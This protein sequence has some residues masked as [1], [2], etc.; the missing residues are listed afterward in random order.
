MSVA[1]ATKKLIGELGSMLGKRVLVRLTN[2]KSYEGILAGF[3]HP[4]VNVILLNV[5]DQDGATY[6][7][8][9]VRGS[10][11]SEIIA[12]ETPLFD[13]KEFA[14]YITRKLNLHVGDAKP[15]PDAGIVVVL[16]NIRVSEKGVEGSGP[17]A[18]KINS[19]LE[20][21]LEAKRRERGG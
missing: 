10:V 19:L 17:L 20:E 13:P 16:N 21:Y 1:T 14:E 5:H 8:V 7:K 12:M 9:F 2:G 18:N 3:D 4:E 6:P 11:V 15:Y